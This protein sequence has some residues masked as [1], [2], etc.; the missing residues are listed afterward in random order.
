MKD[1]AKI[2][3]VLLKELKN[4]HRFI[5]FMENNVKARNELAINRAYIFLSVLTY[6]MNDGDLSPNNIMYN[7]ELAQ[8]FHEMDEL[9]VQ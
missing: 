3:L 1:I 7:M 9:N 5:E 2:R 4:L 8:A 6:H